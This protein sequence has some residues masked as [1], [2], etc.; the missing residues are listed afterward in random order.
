MANKMKHLLIIFFLGIMA[1][2]N[3]KAVNQQKI[4]TIRVDTSWLFGDTIAPRPALH[5]KE[6]DSTWQY[7]DSIQTFPG[8]ISVGEGVLSSTKTDSVVYTFPYADSLDSKSSGAI[9]A[10]MLSLDSLEKGTLKRKMGRIYVPLCD[11]WINPTYPLS[12]MHG[13]IFPIIDSMKRGGAIFFERPK[14][15]SM[16]VVYGPAKL[17]QG[18]YTLS[19]PDCIIIDSSFTYFKLKKDTMKYEFKIHYSI[20]GVLTFM[21]LFD[22]REA[23]DEQAARES[24]QAEYPTWNIWYVKKLPENETK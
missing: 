22:Y 4:D 1:C 21:P 11:D 23:I 12:M 15:D 8:S 6:I 7:A 24:F 16:P 3:H 10:Y 17:Q 2:N 5:Y 18:D 14:K 13:S 20:P 9:D 19:I